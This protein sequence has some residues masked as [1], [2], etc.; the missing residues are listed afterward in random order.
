MAL[1]S[2]ASASDRYPTKKRYVNQTGEVV[3]IGAVQPV[4]AYAEVPV[5]R[6]LP[7]LQIVT[8]AKTAPVV[9][10][11]PQPANDTVLDWPSDRNNR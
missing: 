7:Q 3:T 4:A 8:V 2:F 11:A 6:I 9:R 5:R 1:C 10:V